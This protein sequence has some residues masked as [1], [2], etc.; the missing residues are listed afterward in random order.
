MRVRYIAVLFL[1]GI[2]IAWHQ[3]SITGAYITIFGCMALYCIRRFEFKMSRIEQVSTRLPNQLD[4]V[5]SQMLSEIRRTRLAYP[6]RSSHIYQGDHQ[7]GWHP[8]VTSSK[9]PTDFV[10]F[11]ATLAPVMMCKH[12]ASSGKML[13]RVPTEDEINEYAASEA[14]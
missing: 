7:T 13:Y 14:W 8:V 11:P 1:I 12:D 4:A 10:N 6:S 2:F 5:V 9:S 3:Q